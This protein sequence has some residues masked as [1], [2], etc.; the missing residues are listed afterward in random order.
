MSINDEQQYL[1]APVKTV[2]LRAREA[3]RTAS[4]FSVARPNRL[5]TAALITGL[6][7]ITCLPIVGSVAALIA[8]YTART[9]V[10]A[11]RQRGRG[12]AVAGIALGWSGLALTGA[13]LIVLL[14]PPM[15]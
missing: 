8:G 6:A 5:A 1:R 9:Q 2:P 13:V 10:A 4:S 7:G 14:I 12:F 15:W 11:R 3:P